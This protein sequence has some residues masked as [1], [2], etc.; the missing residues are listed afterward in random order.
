MKD[1]T[2]HAGTINVQLVISQMTLATKRSTL[3]SSAADSHFQTS[4]ITL[5]CLN[6]QVLVKRLPSLTIHAYTISPCYVGTLSYYL[7]T[8]CIL[9]LSLKHV[10]ISQLV[11]L[12]H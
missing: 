12:D 1:N 6:E 3:P 10:T 5:G 9:Q 7:P 11:S 2:G 8:S 4:F